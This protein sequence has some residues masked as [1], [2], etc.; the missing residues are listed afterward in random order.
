MNRRERG[1]MR[2][3]YIIYGIVLMTL[4]IVLC[5]WCAHPSHVRVSVASAV[6]ATCFHWGVELC[7][8]HLLYV[9]VCDFSTMSVTQ[10]FLCV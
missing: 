9:C 2:V 8:C 5:V 1:G 6:Y 3:V 10:P 4:F 7:M